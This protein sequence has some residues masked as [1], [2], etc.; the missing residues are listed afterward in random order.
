MFKKAFFISLVLLGVVLLVVWVSRGARAPLGRAPAP[1]G[2]AVEAGAGAKDVGGAG[3]VG[4]D[5]QPS[6]TKPSASLAEKSAEESPDGLGAIS[7][8]VASEE[9]GAAIQGA[10]VRLALDV[11]PDAFESLRWLQTVTTGGD[12]RFEFRG[13]RGAPCKLRASAAGRLDLELSGVF[14]GD[15][16]EMALK[17][18]G[19]AP[20]RVV[21]QREEDV[22]RNGEEEALGGREV[23]LEIPDVG[24]RLDATTDARGVFSITGLGESRLEEAVGG[25]EVIVAVP[26]FA[27]AE[28]EST[29]G[30]EQRYL[31]TVEPGITVAG[32][33]LDQATGT[34]IPGATVEADSRCAVSTDD[35]GKYSISGAS[36]TLTALAPGYAVQ[37]VMLDDVT[38][39][40]T[41]AS[42][43]VDFRLKRGVV[44]FGRVADSGG[45]PLRGVRVKIG[46]D[47]LTLDTDNEHLETRILDLLADVTDEKGLYRLEGLSPDALG[48]PGILDLLVSPPGSEKGVLSEVTVEVEAGEVEHDIV[49]DLVKSVAGTLAGADGKPLPGARVLAESADEELYQ[50]CSTDAAGRFELT[51]LPPGKYHFLVSREG[52]PIWI[53]E[54]TVPCEPLSL[55]VEPGGNVAGRV[56]SQRDGEPL[57][58]MHVRL[59]VHKGAV[60]G[61]LEAVTD[62][63][64]RF[65]F[66]EVPPGRFQLEVQRPPGSSPFTGWV[67]LHRQD[68][69]VPGD[70][71]NLQILYPSHPSG[72]VVLRFALQGA[73]GSIL[74]TKEP[75]E[76]RVLSF[77]PSGTPE[78]KEPF[79]L[80]GTLVG[81][82]V[83]SYQ[84]RLREGSYVLRSILASS[85]APGGAKVK[86]ENITVRDGEKV[87]RTVTFKD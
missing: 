19:G 25:S 55:R 86:D 70:S 37:T 87:E 73:D 18:D 58:E 6:G 10:A 76:V 31:V 26:G 17:T 44:I 56:V 40:E 14:P 39:G 50:V 84:V 9:G 34:P 30:G 28:I 67:L 71:S 69:Q 72:W 62:E 29:P 66:A 63:M 77:R 42:A 78:R 27:N 81:R 15:N 48:L 1:E 74:E 65:A 24:W 35:R 46:P 36:D 8:R 12:G 21:V 45:R 82:A 60:G 33:V 85:P 32:T 47:D 51:S 80:S 23:I 43:R 22:E 11:P 4:A 54:V 7:G 52:R 64:G 38:G 41:V 2:K 20:C 75:V 53:G 68:V 13:L 16:V 83:G 59:L 5:I 61:R 79:A 57:P 3:G 49:L